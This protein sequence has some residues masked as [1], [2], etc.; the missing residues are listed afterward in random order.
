MI[1]LIGILHLSISFISILTI[2]YRY[3][4]YSFQIFFNYKFYLLFFSLFYISLPCIFSNFLE[5][6]YVTQNQNTIKNT[7]IAG[8]YFV[9]IFFLSYLFSRDYKFDS[10]KIII[11]ND[12]LLKYG[13]IFLLFL[14]SAYISYLIYSNIDYILVLYGDRAAQSTFNIYLENNYKVKSLFIFK[15]MII[16]YLI[17]KTKKKRYLA[18]YMPYVIYDF[19]LAGRIYLFGTLVT[20]YIFLLM[21]DKPIKLKSFF[22]LLVLVFLSILLRIDLELSVSNISTGFIGALLG[23][24]NYTWQTTHLIYENSKSQE[25]SSAFLY[26]FFRIFPSIVYS[27]LFGDYISFAR[28]AGSVNPLGW[29]LAGSIVAEALAFKNI[30]MLL[31]FPIIIIIYGSII[32]FFLRLRTITGA[33]IFVIAV[34]YVQQIFR[35]SFLELAMYPFYVVIF[36]GFAYTTYDLFISS[37]FRR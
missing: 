2:F 35:Y 28:I 29:G 34:I 15:I 9:F 26:A 23:E 31:L 7:S 19:L 24:F 3:L 17:L 25:I 30:F 10:S 33:M 6:S 27:S 16:C 22:V 14:I 1:T 36:L 37:K 18:F 13:S 12:K 4:K 11:P 8:L 20:T 5:F 21:I 32:N